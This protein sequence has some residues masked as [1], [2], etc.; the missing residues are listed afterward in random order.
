MPK[1]SQA[2]QLGAGNV[3]ACVIV[4][5]MQPKLLSLVAKRIRINT[6]PLVECSVNLLARQSQCQS[7]ICPSFTYRS[8][9]ASPVQHRTDKKPGAIGCLTIDKIGDKQVWIEGAKQRMISCKVYRQYAGC[10]VIGNRDRGPERDVE[11]T[12]SIVTDTV[13]RISLPIWRFRHM[14]RA[15]CILNFT[16]RHDRR[17]PFVRRSVIVNRV[18]EGK[19]NVGTH[20]LVFEWL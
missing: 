17:N 12:Q 15:V 2:Q 4:L 16:I 3:E 5:L 7:F 6:D 20:L 14:K 11:V 10:E 19:G 9:Y 8:T 1:I 18:F 13:S